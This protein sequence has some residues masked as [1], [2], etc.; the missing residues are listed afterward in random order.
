MRE[1]GLGA[2]PTTSQ[3][4]RPHVWIADRDGEE[5][6]LQVGT[7][8]PLHIQ[9]G[10]P[11]SP[12]LVRGKEG[13]ILVEDIPEQGLHTDWVVR[14]QDV[15]LEEHPD[16]PGVLIS[17]ATYDEGKRPDHTVSERKTKDKAFQIWSARFELMIHRKGE[18]VVRKIRIRPINPDRGRIEFLVYLRG[19]MNGQ[20]LSSP[21]D[22]STSIC[23][24]RPTQ[25]GRAS[26]DA[27]E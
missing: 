22:R 5:P 14:S 11:G 26:H 27:R 9:M 23:R 25:E 4:K 7:T 3:L 20:V 8:Y 21:I 2:E 17:V 12:T 6:P 24:W 10:E 19:S 15:A 18:S 16:D 13:D 1:H